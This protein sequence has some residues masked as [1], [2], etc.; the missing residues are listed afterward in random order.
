MPFLL[1]FRDVAFSF[2][3]FIWILVELV[4]YYLSLWFYV[5]ARSPIWKSTYLSLWSDEDMEKST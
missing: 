5:A 2:S 1:F 3:L 4:K